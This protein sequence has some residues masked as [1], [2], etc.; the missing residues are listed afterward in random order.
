MTK[1][2]KKDFLKVIQNVKVSDRYASNISHCARV[3]EC[4]LVG[5]KSHDSHILMS[6]LMSIALR[7]SLMKKVVEPLI[8]LSGFFREICS[9]TLRLENLD[10][11]ES[12]IPYI[13]CQ[14]ERIFPSKCFTVMVHL[15]VHLATEYKLSGPVYYRW[16][17]PFE[18][19]DIII[20]QSN[21]LLCFYLT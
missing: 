13:L 9:K 2:E 5:L 1:K 10:R 3:K 15:L 12:R 16:M 19:Y 8:A 7:G 18:R 20:L 6:Q 4:S 21:I 17:Y 11:L 14:L